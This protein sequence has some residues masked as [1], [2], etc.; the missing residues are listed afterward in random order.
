MMGRENPRTISHSSLRKGDKPNMV[1]KK[2]IFTTA[3]CKPKESCVCVCV[4]VLSTELVMDVTRNAP[5]KDRKRDISKKK[6][7]K[8][9]R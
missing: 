4:C 2:G 7:E 3:I 8:V 1:D 5:Q 9:S 6:K